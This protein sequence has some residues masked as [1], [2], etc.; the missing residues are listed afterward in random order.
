MAIPVIM[1]RQGQ[2]VETCIITRWFKTQGEKV[3]AG[4]LLFAYETDKAAFELESPAEGTLLEIFF[5]EG[6]EVPVLVN[7][8]VIGQPGE[9]TLSFNP[10]NRFQEALQKRQL[11]RN[12]SK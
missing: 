9:S 11:L 4:D 3:S 10:R 2:S 6:A 5:G 12:R 8:A 1:P 7:V